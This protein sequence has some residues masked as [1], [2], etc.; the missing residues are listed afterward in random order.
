MR[1]LITAAF[2]ALFAWF[3]VGS[4]RA[5]DPSNARRVI[6]PV[7]IDRDAARQVMGD[8]P[9]IEVANFEMSCQEC[10]GL[11][12][13]KERRPGDVKQHAH[14]RL[15]HGLNDRCHNCHHV[16]DRNLLALPGG[17]SLPYGEVER[18]CASCHGPT[19]RDWQ[20]GI[21][22]KS[23]GT[24]ETSSPEHHR[25]VCTE[26]HDP[27]HPAFRPIA[28]LPPPF[29]PHAGE[30]QHS[31]SHPSKEKRNPLRIHRGDDAAPSPAEKP[32]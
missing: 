28:P 20:K 24:W 3:S 9:R 10:H 22:G 25:M 6:D 31:A 23:R 1:L 15:E 26:C 14:I 5:L 7:D 16:E 8:P 18:L 19:Y 17:E 13:S 12:D 30:A 21:H 4:S 11:F 2:L 32:H 27:H 29:K